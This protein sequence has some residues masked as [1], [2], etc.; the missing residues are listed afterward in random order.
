MQ[1]AR[2][3]VSGSLSGHYQGSVARRASDRLNPDY[4][5]LRPAEVGDWFTV[6]AV[7]GYK[8]LQ[9]VKLEISASNLFNSNAK[10]VK[11][12]DYPFDYS[13]EGRRLLASLKVNL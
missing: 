5:A 1:Y 7:A 12:F 2:D 10:L 9:R 3:H 13:L 6:D 8:I 11:N 4:L